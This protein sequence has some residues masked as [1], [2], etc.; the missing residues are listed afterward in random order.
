MPKIKYVGLKTDGER[1][2]AEKTGIV[3]MPG[4]VHDVSAAHAALMAPHDDVWE[5]VEDT[6]GGPTLADAVTSDSA[7]ASG[8]RSDG[9]I[10]ASAEYDIDVMDDASVHTLAKMRGYAMHNRL[11]GANLRAKF[12]DAERA[13]A[14]EG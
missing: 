2:F 6:A 9:G 5:L 13:A 14:G 12:R 4:D 10:N 7:V 3:W 11:A 1:A 8:E